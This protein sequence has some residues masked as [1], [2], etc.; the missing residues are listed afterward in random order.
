MCPFPAKAADIV[1]MI[2]R[3]IG[4]SPHS[5]PSRPRLP[6]EMP[7]NTA[8]RTKTADYGLDS[9]CRKHEGGGTFS[10]LGRPV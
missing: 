3:A 4:T 2:Y 10:V 8:I 9:E 1:I 7:A 6:A 5:A